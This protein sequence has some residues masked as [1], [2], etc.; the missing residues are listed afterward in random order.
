MTGVK[1]YN[2]SLSQWQT[3]S[4]QKSD[5]EAQIIYVLKVKRY[6]RHSWGECIMRYKV[7]CFQVSFMSC[8]D[9]HLEES[10]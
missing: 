6:G 4:V 3:S 1:W 7:A 5:P 8:C 9:L 2:F 10:I